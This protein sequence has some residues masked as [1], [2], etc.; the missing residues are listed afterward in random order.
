MTVECIFHPGPAAVPCPLEGLEIGGKSACDYCRENAAMASDPP[1]I[2]VQSAPRSQ[3][4]L[5]TTLFWL[6]KAYRYLPDVCYD[7]KGLGP[8][9]NFWVALNTLAMRCPR[10]KYYALFED[11][12]LVAPTV[13]KEIVEWL[14]VVGE[15]PA[16]LSLRYVPDVIERWSN[17]NKWF[18]TQYAWD[19][20]GSQ[21]LVWT[22]RGLREFL[23]HGAALEYRSRGPRQGWGDEDCLTGLWA[24]RHG[25]AWMCAE[26]LL[27]HIGK[28]A[29]DRVWFDSRPGARSHCYYNEEEAA[30]LER[31]GG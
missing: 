28:V 20:P 23:H 19:L 9:G 16:V 4:Y 5:D 18:Q 1:A 6:T 12:V 2:I 31:Y 8:L 11:D 13:D 17:G 22:P 10:A 15:T 14:G 7:D 21:G 27:A 3:S 24:T 25:G 30:F 29:S 26:I